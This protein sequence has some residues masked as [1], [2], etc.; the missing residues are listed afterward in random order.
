MNKVIKFG[1][2]W[3]SPCKV[4]GPNYKK[5]AEEV[6]GKGI[7]VLDL[8]VDTNSDEASK[9][10]VRNIPLTVFIKD[11]E[12]VDKMTGVIPTNTL[13]DKYAEVYQN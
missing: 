10:G 8:D 4:Y 3:C 2:V 11:G 13:L 6:S 12:V 7:D 9:Y 1:A 5:F